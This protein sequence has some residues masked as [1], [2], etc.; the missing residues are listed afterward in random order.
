[1]TSYRWAALITTLSVS[2]GLIGTKSLAITLSL[3]PS[4]L[5]W[6]W[7]SVATLIKRIRYFLPRWNT[8]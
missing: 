1:M 4:I 2:Y 7:L 6:N 8:V 5:N 3:W